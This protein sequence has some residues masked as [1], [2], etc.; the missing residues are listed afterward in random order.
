M[1]KI[2]EK[3]DN[4][5]QYAKQLDLAMFAHASLSLF[6]NNDNFVI[7]IQKLQSK[8]LDKTTRHCWLGI[9]GIQFF[10]ILLFILSCFF[11]NEIISFLLIFN[12]IVVVGMYYYVINGNQKI[13]D[14][15]LD[16]YYKSRR[17][18]LAKLEEQIK[19]KF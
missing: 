6:E 5:K 14:E 7:R 10:N 2:N 19:D 12:L 8:L 9:L 17:N 11:F 3:D 15:E 13:I 18:I 4:E 16:K 1:Q